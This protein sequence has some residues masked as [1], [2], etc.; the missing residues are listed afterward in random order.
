MNIKIY[1]RCFADIISDAN[2]ELKIVNAAR[3]SFNKQVSD[4][5]ERDIRLINYLAKHK[6]WTTF[7]HCRE[8]FVFNLS[9]Y[10]DN[11]S[12]TDIAGC[13]WANHRHKSFTRTSLYGWINIANKLSGYF[14]NII[15]FVNTLSMDAKAF[16]QSTLVEIDSYL[17]MIQT[18]NKT[19]PNS[20][21]ALFTD[22][23]KKLLNVNYDTYVINTFNVALDE[24]D[25][26]RNP[27]FV[28][29]TIKV[30]APIFVARQDFK[31]M[32]GRTF[33][34]V[35]RRYVSDDVEV[36]IPKK[37][38]AKHPLAKQGSQFESVNWE[39]MYY[40]EEWLNSQITNQ[41]R[42][43]NSLVEDVKDVDGNIDY[44]II[45]C[46]EQARMVL[47]QAMMTEYWVTGNKT[48]F[49]RMIDQRLDP[50]AQEEIR[51]LAEVIDQLIN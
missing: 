40:T 36:Y 7:S 33:N 25:T 47:P 41:V 50:H 20:C 17:Y 10:L 14:T 22:Q 5:S 9:K 8:T 16:Q 1:D 12:A 3:V 13:V 51:Q 43:Y 23:T 45:I 30:K 46:P 34:E 19:Y 27:D 2:S 24:F 32:V 26:L 35:S 49:Q 6:H 29:Y 37:W 18:L 38:R 4:L 28:D 44:D 39:R 15:A 21:A 48:A 31:H 11:L 42:V